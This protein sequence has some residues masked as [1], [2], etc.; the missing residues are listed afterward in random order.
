[1]SLHFIDRYP[2]IGTGEVDGFELHFAWVWQTP[3]LRITF[4]ELDPALLGR[5]THLE[6]LPRLAAAPDNLAWLRQDDPARTRAVLD[7]AIS[8]WRKKDEIFRTCEG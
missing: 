6:G 2:L 8:L 1:V 4:A 3:C 5:V 7:L